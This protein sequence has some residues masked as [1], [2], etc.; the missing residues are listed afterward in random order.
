MGQ[1][2]RDLKRYVFGKTDNY[3]KGLLKFKENLDWMW[4][5]S[6]GEVKWEISIV[7]LSKKELSV[8]LHEKGGG[9]GV[10]LIQKRYIERD[11][12]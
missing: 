4:W 12:K 11:K 10:Y 7:R 8:Y 1:F 3:T 9:I 5:I 6:K 2:K